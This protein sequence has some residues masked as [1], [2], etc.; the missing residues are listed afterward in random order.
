MIHWK[1]LILLVVPCLAACQANTAQVPVMMPSLSGQLRI[2][3][4]PLEG[5][6]GAESTELKT[7]LASVRQDPRFQFDKSSAEMV[8][9]WFCK[10]GE[11]QGICASLGSD[12]LFAYEEFSSDGSGRVILTSNGSEVYTIP[13]GT[14]SPLTNLRGLWTYS[15]HWVL[16]TVQVNIEPEGNQSTFETSGNIIRD[17]ELLNGRYGYDESY[18]FQFLNGRPFYLFR[19]HENI[20]ANFDGAEVPLGYDQIIHYGCCSESTLNPVKYEDHL[21]FF[22]RKSADW[23]YVEIRLENHAENKG[24]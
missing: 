23:Y 21:D 6:P 2:V 12:D 4:Y 19:R 7:I 1:T 20:D 11:R 22:A 15:G 24:L 9:A 8:I 3:E 13:I 17:G 5:L 16:E 18:E 10:V 14:A